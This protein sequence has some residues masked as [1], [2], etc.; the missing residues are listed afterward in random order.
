MPLSVLELQAILRLSFA[1]TND[2]DHFTLK[3]A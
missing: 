1:C 2:L 3:L